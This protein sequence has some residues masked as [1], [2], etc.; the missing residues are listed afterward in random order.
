[1][2][3]KKLSREIREV[4]TVY[5]LIRI[6]ISK[7]GDEVLTITPEYEDCRKIAEE[8]QIPLK[9]VM[10]EAKNVFSRKGAKDAK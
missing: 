7:R 2:G 1:V 3:R 5:G 10:E 9:Q 8:K 4:E 6:K